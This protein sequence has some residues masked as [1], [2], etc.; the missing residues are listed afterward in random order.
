MGIFPLVESLRHELLRDEDPATV[1]LMERLGAIK[2][3]GWF[4]R[5]EFLEM[6]RW[7]SPRALRHYQTNSETMIRLV[8]RPVLATRSERKRIQLL[9]SF[10]GVSVTMASAILGDGQHGLVVMFLP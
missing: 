3:R 10:R 6:C 8:S 5:R 9:R 1:K 4:S 2:R 7:K